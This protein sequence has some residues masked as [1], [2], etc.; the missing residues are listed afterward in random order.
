MDI[1]YKINN[2]IVNNYNINK[3]NYNN[4]KNIYNIKNTLKY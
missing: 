1:Y 2:N 3:R 4:L